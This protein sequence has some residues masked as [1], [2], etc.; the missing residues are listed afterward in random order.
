[1]LLTKGHSCE[2]RL[3]FLQEVRAVLQSFQTG[4]CIGMLAQGSCDQ[5]RAIMVNLMIY[6]CLQVAHEVLASRT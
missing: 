2:E 6:K 3:L 1:M 5:Q 4:C